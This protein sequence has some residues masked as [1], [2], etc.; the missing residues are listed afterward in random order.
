[1]A[2]SHERLTPRSTIWTRNFTCAMLAQFFLSVS[3]FAVNT[4][5]ATYTKHLGAE[6]VLMGFLTGMF[7]G[8]ALAIRPISGPLMTRVDKRLL[9]IFIS[10]L[11]SVVNIGYALFR[12]IPAFIFFRFLHGVQYSFVGALNMTVAS[13]ALPPEKMATGIGVFGISSAIGQ[14]VGP[15][16]GDSLERFGER[17]LG[18]DSGFT[19]VFLFAAVALAIAVIPCVMLRPDVKPKEALKNVGAWYKNIITVHALPTTFVN[20]FMSVASALYVSYLLDFGRVSGIDNMNLFFLVTAIV[21]VV[22]RP[23]AGYLMDHY[24]YKIV[25]IPG[26]FLLIASYLVVGYSKTLPPILFA[27]VL[28]ALGTAATTPALQAMCMQSVPPIKRSVASNTLYTGIDLALFTGPLYGSI[29]L[30]LSD[31]STMF[32]FG[33]VPIVLGLAAFIIV[34]PVYQR[35][36]Q[37]LEQAG[38]EE[39]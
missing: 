23:L 1:M 13:D 7:F 34:Y 32:K 21:L 15:T 6:P 3:H 39:E 4:L 28:S 27:S 12:S 33:V 18:A 14:A 37:E 11:G 35:R 22:S 26:M 17:L 10:I 20:F 9:M 19:L 25:V 16:I 24:G 31:Y 30:K 8:V 2:S 5:V 36:R 29:V 38:R